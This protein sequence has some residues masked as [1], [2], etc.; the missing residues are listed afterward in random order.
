MRGVICKR[1]VLTHPLTVIRSFGWQV[2]LRALAAGPN[3]TFLSIIAPT[4]QN[5]TTPPDGVAD[6]IERCVDLE[7]RARDLYLSL[8]EQQPKASPLADFLLTLAAQEQGHAEL[9]EYCRNLACHTNWREE[10]VACWRGVV[11]VL[12][13][14]MGDVEGMMDG[15]TD[16][17]RILETVIA[18]EGSE[19]NNLFR[20][21]VA[22]TDN[23]FVRTF[24]S[25]QS[26]E[27]EHIDFICR[28]LPRLDPSLSNACAKLAER[29]E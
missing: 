15:A 17:T 13:K 6:F 5:S 14:R 8:S 7:K 4:L 20:G 26:A 21:V 27:A 3:R 9:L 23:E 18:L 28:E 19:I 10:E 12:E 11:P 29:H 24:Q 2:F 1:H 22:A 16:T 25:F